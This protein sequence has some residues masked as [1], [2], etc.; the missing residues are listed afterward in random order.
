MNMDNCEFTHHSLLIS[1]SKS[2]P[3]KKI[4]ILVNQTR[5]TMI[6]VISKWWLQMFCHLWVD[7]PQHVF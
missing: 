7:K 2:S 6:K 3:L 1:F 4:I 5:R